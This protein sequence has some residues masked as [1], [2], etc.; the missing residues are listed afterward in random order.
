ML[1]KS[2]KKFIPLASVSECESLGEIYFKAWRMIP[3]ERR[4]DVEFSIQD[5]MYNAVVAYR[6]PLGTVEGGVNKVIAF[7][8]WSVVR[9]A[10]I[11]HSTGADEQ[12]PFS[13]VA[14]TAPSAKATY[15]CCS[16][17]QPLQAYTLALLGSIEWPGNLK[18]KKL[19]FFF[20]CKS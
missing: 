16:N 7:S 15:R 3:E 14:R 18:T 12:A 11:P 10:L 1:Q 19:E 17:P 6:K 4:A 2:V 9:T 13:F 5:L 20:L 8:H